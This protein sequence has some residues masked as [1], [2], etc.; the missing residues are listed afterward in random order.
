MNDVIQ[1]KYNKAY[2]YFIMLLFLILF[3]TDQARDY[4]WLGFHNK[5]INNIFE[6]ALLI[7]FIYFIV[8][9]F[10]PAIKGQTALELNKDE[11][12]DLVKNAKASWNNVYSI[13]LINYGRFKGIAI[14][15]IDSEEFLRKKNY[16]QKFRGSLR[17]Y[18]YDTPMVISLE[19][20]A[21]DNEGILQ[22]I[23]EYMD[24][25]KSKTSDQNL[26]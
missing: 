9:I 3:F 18:F 15:L 25:V 22:T 11:I 1:F 24:K 23:Q 26:R 8:K 17:N 12:V 14:D 5:N 16:W 6:M 2:A 10:I 13:R 7:I 20:L 21:G 4:Y 19:Y